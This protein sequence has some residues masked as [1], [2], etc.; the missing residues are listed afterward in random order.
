MLWLLL[1]RFDLGGLERVQVNLAPAFSAA[2]LDVCIVAGRFVQEAKKTIPDGM[3]TLE[4]AAQGRHRF[5]PA[6]LAALRKN[7]PHLV[8]TTSNDVA[9]MMLVIRALIYP[10]MKIVC[11]QHLSLS[12]PMSQARGM[13]RIKMGLVHWMMRRLLPKADAIIAVSH[14]LADD[15]QRTLGLQSGIEVIHNPIM[16]PC[17]DQQMRM[18]IDWPWAD[19]SVPTVIFVG[20]LAQVKRTDLLLES[21]R[22]LVARTP[23]RLL[24]LGDGPERAHLRQAITEHGLDHMC[25]LAGFH[26]NPL[27]WV[28]NSDLLV[29]PSDY[30]GFGNVLV[31]AMGCG[32]QVVSTDCPDGPAEILDGGR[33]GQLVPLGDPSALADAMYRSLTG[34]FHVP[35]Q[36]L[37]RRANEFSLERAVHSYLAVIQSTGSCGQKK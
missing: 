16:L 15:M 31:E 19:K 17:F 6:L 2:G 25:H 13:K 11:T 5:I 24:V 34:A 33:Y 23:A 36:D 4:I 26:A 30:E 28:R 35:P 9:C 10:E 32:V 37:V 1:S 21:F 12:G 3:S 14:A 7:R 22:R 20:R 8:M 29:L 27:P 18:S